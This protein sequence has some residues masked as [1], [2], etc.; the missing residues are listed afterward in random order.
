M[1][2]PLSFSKK[3]FAY[4][5]VVEFAVFV[6][7]CVMVVITCDTSPLYWIVT[8]IGAEISVYSAAYLHKAKVENR[9]KYAQAYITDIA[10]KY[11]VDM[12][13]RVAE[14]VLKD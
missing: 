8:A 5:L 14:V 1:K 10:D 13:V 7:I 9:H 11:G 4:L 2:E 12:A 3:Y 6:F